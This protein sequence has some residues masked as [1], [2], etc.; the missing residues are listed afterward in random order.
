MGVWIA[1][2]V[3]WIAR[4]TSRFIHVW[5]TASITKQHDDPLSNIDYD[6]LV[7]G[8]SNST[9][10]LLT[11]LHRGQIHFL[12]LIF[13]SDVSLVLNFWRMSAYSQYPVRKTPSSYIFHAIEI[14]YL[15]ECISGDKFCLKI[16]TRA[17]PDNGWER[18]LAM[19]IIDS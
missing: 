12:R 2:Q 4:S 1:I 5:C 19:S 15:L 14:L 9:V 13:N 6:G 11:T 7:A 8:N 10:K 3:F 16:S 18:L 17:F